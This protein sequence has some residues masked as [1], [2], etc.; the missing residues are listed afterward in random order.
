M[1]LVTVNEHLQGC[2][3]PTLLAHLTETLQLF[4]AGIFLDYHDTLFEWSAATHNGH[5]AC[6]LV[7]LLT[8]FGLHCPTCL[9]FD[10]CGYLIVTVGQRGIAKVRCYPHLISRHEVSAN[11]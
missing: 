11:I 4:H 9:F 3:T 5:P 8:V 1:S 6:F 7:H 10:H 2:D